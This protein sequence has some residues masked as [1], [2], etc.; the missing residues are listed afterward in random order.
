MASIF[1]AV[2]RHRPEFFLP[3]P[4]RHLRR[5]LKGVRLALKCKERHDVRDARAARFA[6]SYRRVPDDVSWCSVSC[7]PRLSKLFFLGFLFRLGLIG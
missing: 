1:I 4:I 2:E 5:A 3:F 7:N 6:S